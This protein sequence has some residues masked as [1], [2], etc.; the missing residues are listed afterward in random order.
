L[1]VVSKAE[2]SELRTIRASEVGEYGYC[3][4]AWWYR[5]VV[6]LPPPASGDWG[7]L[8]EGTRAHARL[9]RRVQMAAGIRTVGIVLALCG[10]AL[11]AVMLLLSIGGRGI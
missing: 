5:Y 11:L 8:A 4:R 10:L 1:E 3:S 7:R 6:K 2:G 9:G